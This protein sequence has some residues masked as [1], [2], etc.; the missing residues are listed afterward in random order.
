MLSEATSGE[1]NARRLQPL[2]ERHPMPGPRRDVDDGVGALL[3]HLQERLVRGHGL[4]RPAR[5]GIA[6]VEMQD[7]GSGLGGAERCRGNLL[8]RDREGSRTW[9]GYESTPSP[10]R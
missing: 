7:G 1:K 2:F 8:R 3:D 9:R 10:R 6:G 5:E 4:Q